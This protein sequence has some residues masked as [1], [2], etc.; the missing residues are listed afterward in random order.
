MWQRSHLIL[1]LFNSQI[2]QPILFDIILHVLVDV[3]QQEVEGED[4]R[5]NVKTL[6]Q[7]VTAV[8]VD[9]LQTI[10]QLLL[11]YIQNSL[12]FSGSIPQLILTLLSLFT[13]LI[14]IILH[15]YNR[16]THIRIHHIEVVGLP[17]LALFVR[18]LP[19]S[20]GKT[21]IGIL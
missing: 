1:L 2:L 7:L 12:Y 19:L 17:N 20:F 15:T 21:I 5:V 13:N 6:V 14:V 8:Y 10:L 9:L 4:H 3:A 11:Q 18:L 16:I